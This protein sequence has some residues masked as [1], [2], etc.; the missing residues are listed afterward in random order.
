MKGGRQRDD[1]G[2]ALEALSSQERRYLLRAV[3]EADPDDWVAVEDALADDGLASNE[4]VGD[5]GRTSSTAPTVADEEPLLVRAH[6]QHLP[7]LVDRGYVR[8]DDAEGRVRRGPDF[9][10]VAPVLAL[11]DGCHEQ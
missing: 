3:V 9:E 5:G 8:W 11:L 4:L 2:R 7:Y 1:L 6:H 10:E